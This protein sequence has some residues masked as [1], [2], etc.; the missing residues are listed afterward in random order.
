MIINLKSETDLSAF[1]V[2]YNGSVNI[3]NVGERGVSHLLEHLVAKAV[4]HL[5]DEYDTEGIEFNAY[6]SNNEI[7]FYI[8]G[9][10]EKIENRRD[11]FLNLLSEFNITKEEFENE[12]SIVLEEYM[13]SFSDPTYWHYLNLD[14]KL[15]NNYNPIGSKN[16]LVNFTYINCIDFFKKQFLKPT[17]V[18]NVSK[19]SEFGGNIDFAKKIKERDYKYLENN[20]FEL[21]GDL[22]DSV[23]TSLIML[24]PIFEDNFTVSKMINAMLSKGLNSPLYQE[25]REK[26]GLVYYIS[27]Y[28]SR[29]SEKGLVN[30]ST[31]TSDENV[32]KILNIIKTIFDNPE[33]FLTQERFDICKESLLVSFKK[34]DILRYDSIGKYISPDDWDLEKDIENITL[35]KCIEVFNKYYKFDDF[36]ISDSKKEFK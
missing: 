14:R 17:K 8:K 31:L 7:V 1:Y 3:E 32:D 25:I 15:F 12:K 21:E 20:D 18:I 23:K 26:R 4:D 30:I 6:T 2:V 24:S 36:Y 33:K 22:S 28:T 10:D 19:G 35:E 27:M 34:S 9:L 5:Q 16:D 11:E 29:I 13:D